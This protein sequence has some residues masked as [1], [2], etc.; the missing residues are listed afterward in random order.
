MIFLIVLPSMNGFTFSEFFAVVSKSAC[1]AFTETL[2]TSRNLP[3][4]CTGISI[5]LSTSS[6]ASNFGHG[7]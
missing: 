7:A 1:V 6:A 5:S 3:F 2:I 4:T